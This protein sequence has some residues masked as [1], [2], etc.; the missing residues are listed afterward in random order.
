M[1]SN[2]LAKNLYYLREKMGLKQSEIQV[3]LGVKRNTIS[4]WE[5][6]ISEPNLNKLIFISEYFNVNLSDLV[7]K[8]LS[9]GGDY[10][11]IKELKN[12]LKGGF[13]GGD[14]GGDWQLNEPKTAYNTQ[15]NNDTET[16][17]LLRTIIEDKTAT[18]A[19]LKERIQE[20]KQYNHTLIETIE[21]MRK[22]GQNTSK[23]KAAG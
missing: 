18:I 4:N 12:G 16:A 9:K 3:Q 8:N 20:L 19:D 14:E 2:F 10:A 22:M 6:G 11:K 13:Y 15:K 23:R 1:G 21:E 7:Q 17:H 5:N